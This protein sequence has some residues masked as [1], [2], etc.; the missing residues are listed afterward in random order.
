MVSRKI[1]LVAYYNPDADCFTLEFLQYAINI[2]YE[3]KEGKL[4]IKL[5]RVINTI[6]TEKGK[7]AIK[8]ML[9]DI[10]RR[11]V[12]YPYEDIEVVEARDYD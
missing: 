6:F 10:A 7:E 5:P 4:V 2:D 11:R 9:V 1:V 8:E 3:R 12:A